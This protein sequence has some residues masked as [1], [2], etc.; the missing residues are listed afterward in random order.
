MC[1]RMERD[2]WKP[3]P[4]AFDRLIDWVDFCFCLISL[5]LAPLIPFNVS[6]LLIFYVLLP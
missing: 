4:E 5:L 2:G 3:G 1:R 6:I